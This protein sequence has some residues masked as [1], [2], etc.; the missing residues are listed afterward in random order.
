MRIKCASSLVASEAHQQPLLM[1][2][3]VGSYAE[4]AAAYLDHVASLRGRSRR[5]QVHPKGQ[6]TISINGTATS[7]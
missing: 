5:G 6:W 2:W 4:Q 1:R 7:S 3:I